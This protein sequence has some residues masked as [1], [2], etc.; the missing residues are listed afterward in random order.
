[1]LFDDIKEF[2]Y[3]SSQEPEFPFDE[4]VPPTKKEIHEGELEEDDLSS[5]ED[6][7]ADDDEKEL[8]IE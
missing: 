1:M 5:E 3:N 6:Y 7:P 4:E 8:G 2:I